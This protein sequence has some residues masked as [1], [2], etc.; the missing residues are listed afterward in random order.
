[1]AREFPHDIEAERALIGAMLIN[2]DTCRDIL[3]K[4]NTSDFFEVKHQILFRTLSKMEQDQLPIDVMTVTSH[5]TESN[6]IN[7][8]GGVDYLLKLVESVPTVA[9]TNYYLEILRN[10]A[11][12]RNVIIKAENIS[13][14]AFSPVEDMNAFID[15]VEREIRD[16]TDDR[17]SGE[18]QKMQDVLVQVSS[19]MKALHGKAGKISGVETKFI[20][21]DRITAGFQPSD[22][23]IL[24]ARPAM[25]KTAFALNIASN[26]SYNSSSPVVVFSLEMPAIQLVQRI[27]SAM[28]EIDSSLLR[29]GD[30]LNKETEADFY[31]ALEKVKKCNLFIDDTPG[32][33]INEIV[34]KCRKLHKENPIKLVLIDYLQLIT[35]GSGKR[36]ENR[37]QEVSD[38]SRQLKALARELNAPVIAL[39]QLSRSVEQRTDKRPMLS[40]LRES[41]AIEQDADIVSFIYR[42][43]YYL[44]AEKQ[45]ETDD[46][47]AEIIIAKHRN[48]STGNVELAF[49]K[50]YSRF[51]NLAKTP[52]PNLKD[53]RN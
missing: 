4:A 38:I 37:Q 1:M 16:I 31:S 42:A 22:L 12:L 7:N 11:I 17:R 49:R 23:I 47:I 28:G 34:A 8:A 5:L 15:T 10:K 18:F 2:P 27:I 3:T 41:G 21:L 25:G 51:D 36:S 32:L 29:T 14:L 46:S 50:K 6:E 45:T 33:S 35:S 52:G 19:R 40:D 20:D 13:E 39:S 30:V 53:V 44:S 24:A 9:H 43:D 26:S 48:G